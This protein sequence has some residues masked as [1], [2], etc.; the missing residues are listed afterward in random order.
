MPIYKK[1]VNGKLTEF[2]VDAK[3]SD[4]VKDGSLGKLLLNRINTDPVILAKLNNGIFNFKTG[5]IALLPV[6]TDDIVIDE[7]LPN[8]PVVDFEN[9][10]SLLASA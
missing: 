8:T 9:I 3:F 4:I 5:E 1:S 2:V 6:S 7:T 10:R